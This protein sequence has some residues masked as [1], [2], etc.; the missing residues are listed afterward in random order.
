[1]AKRIVAKTGEYTNQQGETK[2]RWTDI[3]VIMENQHGEYIMLNPTVDLA[4]VLMKQRLFAQANNSRVG[5]N[6]MCSIFEND[7]AGTQRPNQ[8]NSQQPPQQSPGGN[9]GFDDDV[10]F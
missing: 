4:G 6:V 1:M 8:Q 3:G 2:G 5:D 10:P 9:D 7:N